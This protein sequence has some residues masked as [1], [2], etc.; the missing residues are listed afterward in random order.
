MQPENNDNPVATDEQPE[1]AANGSP[2]REVNIAFLSEIAAERD[3]AIK[4]K[5]ELARSA[6]EAA[7]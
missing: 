7:G 3:R 6:A 4:E 1:S 5:A 2:Q